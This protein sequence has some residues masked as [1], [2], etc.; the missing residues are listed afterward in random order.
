MQK[1]PIPSSGE[2][3]PVI[4]F[5]T[6]ITFDVRPS[7]KHLALREE[8]LGILF[9]AGGR[10]IDTSPMY[11]RAEDVVGRT[12]ENMG[13]R[14]EA[15]LATKVWT[16]GERAGARQM[17]TSLGLLRT[18]KIELMQIHNLVDWPTQLKTM[19]A[20]KDEGRLRYIGITHYTD[21]GL[22]DLAD[23]I[24]REAVDF[25]QFC[26]GM[27]AREAERRLLPLAADRGVAT[28][29]NKPFSGGDLIQ[30]FK[31]HPLPAWAS[32]FDCSSWGQ[33]FLKFILGHPAIT[34]VIPGTGR[35][36][37]ARDNVR[38]GMGRMPD[39]RARARMLSFWQA[40]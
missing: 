4:G 21:A 31:N 10:V 26:Y 32:E 14:D 23:V 37:S 5:G 3:L 35:V 30:A 25:V 2:M 27:N 7:A 13:R 20:W 8:I 28:L 39:E 9:D 33:F 38:A 29:I 15:F 24:E 34:C 16:R 12:L 17:E 6:W 40:L 19:R 1:R 11:G 18:E 22:D 36:E